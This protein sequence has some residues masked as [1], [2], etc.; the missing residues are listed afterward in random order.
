MPL[1]IGLDV[2]GTKILGVAMDKGKV[3]R[4]KKIA[5]GEPS[6]DAFA[7]SMDKLVTALLDGTP[8]RSATIGIGLPGHSER[9]VLMKAANLRFMEGFNFKKFFKKRGFKKVSVGG[10]AACFALG[11]SVRLQK[12]NLV[13]ITLGTGIGCGIVLEGKIY[14]GLGNAGE[15]AHT[16]IRPNGRKCPCGNRG[17]LEEYFSTRAL[18]RET[19]KVFGKEVDAYELNL[20]CKKGDKLADL[21]C[22][23]LG[24]YLGFCL[25]NVANLI[26]P[27]AIS[28]SGG[29]A[30][31]KLLVKYG[32]EEMRKVI[33]FREPKIVFGKYGSASVGAANLK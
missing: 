26:N 9:G 17:C 33:Y 6:Q 10:D 16:I 4:K 8:A 23:R 32:I 12:R 7:A 30:Q 1:K 19:K 13:G 31:N 24:L 5:V 2:G 20:L 25:G 3:L 11:E 14:H 29:L 28:I 18:L 21:V 22:R 27:E 15:L